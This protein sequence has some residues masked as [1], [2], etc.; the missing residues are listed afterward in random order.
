MGERLAGRLR[1][2]NMYY[3][4]VRRLWPAAGEERQ[5]GGARFI[6]AR[7]GEPEDVLAYRHARQVYPRACGGTTVLQCAGTCSTGL[8]PRV[9]GNLLGPPLYHPL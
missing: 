2:I 1:L 8:S 3:V 7:A 5:R 9:R 6:P 4:N